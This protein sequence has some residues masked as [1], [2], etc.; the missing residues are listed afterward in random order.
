MLRFLGRV[1]RQVPG[2]SEPANIFLYTKSVFVSCKVAHKKPCLCYVVGSMD[3][4]K[5]N[6][7]VRVTAQRSGG[8]KTQQKLNL[9]D[10][11]PVEWRPIFF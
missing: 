6:M 4:R 7:H 3:T 10:K 1:P 9:L 8:T 11:N 5:M 2:V